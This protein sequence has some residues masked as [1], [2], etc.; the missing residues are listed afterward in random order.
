M[1]VMD[2]TA[3]E[4]LEKVSQGGNGVRK[5]CVICQ[6]APNSGRVELRLAGAF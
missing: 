2:E 6:V 1:E 5:Q 4:A 3:G